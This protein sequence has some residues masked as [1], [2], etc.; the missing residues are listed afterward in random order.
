MAVVASN[1][2]SGSGASVIF[3]LT[4]SPDRVSALSGR[5]TRARIRPV[6]H[7]DQLEELA[8][9]RGFPS[10]FGHRHSLLGHP[11]P[12][13][14]VGPSSRSA[15]RPDGRTPTG[16]PRSARTSYDRGGRPLY[17]EDGG[18]HP[19]PGGLPSR[20][21]PLTSGQSL[22]PAPTS[23][24]ARLRL[25]RHQRGFK[26]F[27]RPVFPSPAAARMERAAAWAFPRASHPADQEP[28]DARR[29]GDRPSSTDL[30]LPAQHHIALILQSGSS[31]N[32]C[33][34]ASHVRNRQRDRAR[35]GCCSAA[36]NIGCLASKRRVK[37]RR[38]ALASS[39]RAIRA[40]E[41][42]IERRS[43]LELLDL[44]HALRSMTCRVRRTAR[45]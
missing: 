32:T 40:S 31:L 7:D 38:R 35:R 9:S 18:A 2:S 44:G 4:G 39:A 45:C 21:L 37:L 10:P 24:R 36:C 6:I 8:C 41:G 28:D 26:Q 3:L 30:E 22:H 16:L 34:L 29:G 43:M 42:P 25:T 19:G 15:Y 17:P 5:A 20:R 11:V 27:T 12:A 33:D 23:H 1:L 13:E 14:G